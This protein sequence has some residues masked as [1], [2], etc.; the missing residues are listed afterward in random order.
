MY[1]HLEKEK[2]RLS[3]LKISIVT[4]LIEKYKELGKTYISPTGKILLRIYE[5]NKQTAIKKSITENTNLLQIIGKPETLLLAYREIKGNKEDLSK[6][7]ILPKD[8][9]FKK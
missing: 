5:K 9:G 3:T 1:E 7:S 8:K 4:D 6:G 2:L